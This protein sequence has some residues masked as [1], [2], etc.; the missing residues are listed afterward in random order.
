MFW[1]IY[2]HLLKS[3]IALNTI[4]L[5]L[6]VDSVPI[7]LVLTCGYHSSHTDILLIIIMHSY[8]HHYLFKC[9]YS[10]SM[11]TDSYKKIGAP[12]NNG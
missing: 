4:I 7:N 12:I 8:C 6:L 2:N 5:H 3:T 11:L 1:F 9:N 10:H